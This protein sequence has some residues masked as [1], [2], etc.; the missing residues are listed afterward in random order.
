MP[1]ATMASCP[2]P[3]S[4]IREVPIPIDP[5]TGK[6][7]EYRVEEGKAVLAAPPPPGEKPSKWQLSEI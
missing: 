3:L 7:F 1:P 4:E 2:A 5:V 6:E